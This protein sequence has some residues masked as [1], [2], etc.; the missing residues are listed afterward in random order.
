MSERREAVKQ[1]MKNQCVSVPAIRRCCATCDYLTEEG[2]CTEYDATPPIEFLEK[3]N[4]C[5]AYI[6][7]IPF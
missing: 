3:E 7:L 2:V 5:P 1:A 4:D 6:D